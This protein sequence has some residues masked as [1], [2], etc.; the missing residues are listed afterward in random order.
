MRLKDLHSRPSEA[1]KSRVQRGVD[2]AKEE[3]GSVEP[4]PLATMRNG[5][6]G[7]HH[8]GLSY[9]QD[10]WPVWRVLGINLIYEAGIPEQVIAAKG[11]AE[12]KS[13]APLIEDDC[14]NDRCA[15]DAPIEIGGSA[16]LDVARP[17]T[18]QLSATDP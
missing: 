7:K 2:A 12:E 9:F 11:V 10:G 3:V 15:G 16:H 8:R 14:F 6:S 5:L 17:A 1:S 4:G 18:G 13:L